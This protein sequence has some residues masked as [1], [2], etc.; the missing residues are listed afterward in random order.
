[1][2]D[3]LLAEILAAQSSWGAFPS[4]V[5]AGDQIRADENAFVTALVL[6]ILGEVQ[7]AAPR[8]GLAASLRR[9]LDFLESCE[10]PERPGAFLFYPPE[11]P[12]P[13]LAIDL[14]ADADDT[15]LALC[16]LQRHGR[17]AKDDLKHALDHVLEPHRAHFLRG[18][19]PPWVR[20]GAART[21][22]DDPPRPNPVDACVNANVATLYAVASRSGHPA[23]GAAWAT[24]DAGVRATGG[25]AKFRHLL[26][27][28]YLHPLELLDA[29]RRAVRAGV[30]ELEEAQGLL[31]SRPWARSD[32]AA[33]DLHRPIC[34][35]AH[36]RPVWTAPVL[37]KA[38]RVRDLVRRQA[39]PPNSASIHPTTR[40]P[41]G[42][43]S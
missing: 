9:G 15:A 32:R 42:A 31:E 36:G 22:L 21:W 20:Q 13:R 19:E 35:N 41:E 14:V 8:A 5:H 33:A 17:R 12:A 27:P 3:D 29:V 4:R 34:C 38:R 11:L 28:Y 39:S 40:Q 23:Y 10:D 37:Q 1:M 6:E 7:A 25:E 26:T 30:A 2:I 24:V 18:D 16:L 43:T